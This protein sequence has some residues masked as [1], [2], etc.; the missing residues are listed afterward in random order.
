MITL[1]LQPLSLIY[2]AY[3]PQ[4]HEVRLG[5]VACAGFPHVGEALDDDGPYSYAFG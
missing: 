1:S 2:K 4:E 5:G 3:M